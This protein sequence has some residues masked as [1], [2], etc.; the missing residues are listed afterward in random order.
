MTKLQTVQSLPDA[1]QKHA[2]G[3]QMAQLQ[4]QLETQRQSLVAL[5]PQLE[6]LQL[7][8]GALPLEISTLAQA[9]L[10][11]AQALH[12][13][14]PMLQSLKALDLDKRLQAIEAVLPRKEDGTPVMLATQGTLQATHK[15]VRT[16]REQLRTLAT[17]FPQDDQGCLLTLTSEKR[18]I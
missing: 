6:S 9:I 17:A 13:L 8:I 7:Q 3:E 12:H 1:K 10:P 15:E 16:V 14:A 2:T 11:L 5:G 18:L 4:S